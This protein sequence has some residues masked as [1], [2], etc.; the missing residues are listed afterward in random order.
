MVTIKDP[1]SVYEQSVATYTKITRLG[2]ATNAYMTGT[3]ARTTGTYMDASLGSMRPSG[4]VFGRALGRLEHLQLH[5]TALA[6]AW[7]RGVRQA[8]RLF[9]HG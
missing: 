7:V 6:Q 4:N 8:D 3:T 5:A 9:H 1:N 2:D